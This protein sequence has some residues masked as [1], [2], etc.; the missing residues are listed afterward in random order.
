MFEFNSYWFADGGADP[1][2]WMI[3]LGGRMKLWNV[4]DRGLRQSGPAITPILKTGSVELGIDNMDLE[5]LL[6][7][8]KE[9]GRIPWCWKVTKT[10]LT[11]IR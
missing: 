2:D 9:A 5:Y 1:H 3:T 11:M 10:G 4:T 7:I 6:P 8:A